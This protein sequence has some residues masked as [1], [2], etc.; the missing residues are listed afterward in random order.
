V[1]LVCGGITRE[2]REAQLLAEVSEISSPEDLADPESS[3]FD[4]F[5]WLVDVDGAQ[6]CPQDTLDV[7]QR[8]VLAVL[9]YSTSGD[10]WSV[11]SAQIAQSPSECNS[12]RFL[13]AD[14]VCRWFG[15]TCNSAAGNVNTIGI[16][17]RPRKEMRICA[18]NVEPNWMR[19]HFS[20]I[21]TNFSLVS[22]NASP[23]H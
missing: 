4:A 11:C 1:P 6:V 13:D 7:V 15:L 8:Y 18:I 5:Q 12:I 16:G 23:F 20:K 2:E 14:N 17:K 22:L 19:K 21:L 10:G 9:Y 3:Q